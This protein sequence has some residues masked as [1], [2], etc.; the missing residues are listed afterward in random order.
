MKTYPS[1]IHTAAELRSAIAD[2]TRLDEVA[3]FWSSI[4]MHPRNIM[5]ELLKEAR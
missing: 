1:R 5:R 4:P 2:E 3:A